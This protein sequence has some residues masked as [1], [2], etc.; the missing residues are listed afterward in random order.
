[1][2][3]QKDDTEK[4][5][6]GEAVNDEKDNVDDDD[7]EDEDEEQGDGKPGPHDGW[8]LDVLWPDPGTPIPHSQ[9][10]LKRIPWGQTS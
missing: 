9:K 8:L 2:F 6:C 10:I 4:D 7:K 1:M 5:D 3:I